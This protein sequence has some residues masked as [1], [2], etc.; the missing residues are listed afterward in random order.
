MQ[1]GPITVCVYAD[2]AFMSYGGGVFNA[3]TGTYVNHAVV[4]VGWDDSQGEEGVWFM[5]N[6][7]GQWWGE[8]GYMRIAYDT[9]L[10][11]YNA[12]YL[13]MGPME[14]GACCFGGGCLV[15]PESTC[16]N[17]GGTFL[18]AGTGC[19]DDACAEACDSDIDG[20]GAVEA[21]DLLALIAAWGCTTCDAEDVDGDGLVGTNDILT[22][23]A[24]WGNCN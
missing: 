7:W 4:L 22:L 17:V 3:S 1:H 19:G 5:R 6:S 12:L 13:D 18:G 14:S 15:G 11:G 9:S 24:A 21:N 20:N 2:S 10:I 16:D 23:I 8:G